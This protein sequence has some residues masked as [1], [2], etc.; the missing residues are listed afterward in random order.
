M[1]GEND[2]LVASRNSAKLYNDCPCIEKHLKMFEGDHN[3]RRPE[4][5]LNEVM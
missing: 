1:S 5:I 4:K 2:R 3:S